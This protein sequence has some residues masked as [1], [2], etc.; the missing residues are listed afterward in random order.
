[1]C[2]YGCQE[3]RT[4]A[5]RSVTGGIVDLAPLRVVEDIESFGTKLK[6]HILTYRKLFEQTH[7]VVSASRYAKNITTGHR[8]R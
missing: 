5:V 8:Q 7:V 4:I 1:M 3:L 6:V 2:S